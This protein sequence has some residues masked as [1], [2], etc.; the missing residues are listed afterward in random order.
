MSRETVEHIL[1]LYYNQVNTGIN[2]VHIRSNGNQESGTQG[3]VRRPGVRGLDP[4]DWPGVSM[5][6]YGVRQRFAFAP[7]IFKRLRSRLKTGCWT[8]RARDS[9]AETIINRLLQ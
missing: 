8:L 2:R 9:A 4:F 1:P 7:C 6:E 3:G 5:V